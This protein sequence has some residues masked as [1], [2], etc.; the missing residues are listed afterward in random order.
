MCHVKAQNVPMDGTKCATAQHKGLVPREGTKCAIAR[1]TK[2]YVPQDGT[3][4]ATA[5]HKKTYVPREGT[6]CAIARHKK[7]Y[8]LKW[9][10]DENANKNNIFAE[11]VFVFPRELCVI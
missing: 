10:K 7:T 4:C 11:N 8:R 2:T 1:H 3:K 5:R 6:K 9:L